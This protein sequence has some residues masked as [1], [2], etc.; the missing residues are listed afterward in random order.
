M[1]SKCG[2][3]LRIGLA[4]NIKVYDCPAVCCSSSDCNTDIDPRGQVQHKKRSLRRNNHAY[5]SNLLWAGDGY[6]RL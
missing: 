5:W 4:N 2:R 3:K 6:S 1:L